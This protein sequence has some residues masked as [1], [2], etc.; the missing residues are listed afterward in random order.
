ME[1]LRG[2]EGRSYR[3]RRPVGEGCG[4]RFPDLSQPLQWPERLATAT[5][6]R[7]TREW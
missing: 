6:A 5:P 1:G 2:Y 7:W 4:M 3:A